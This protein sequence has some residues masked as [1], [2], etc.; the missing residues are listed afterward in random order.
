MKTKYS[1]EYKC[2]N[3]IHFF[4][5]LPQSTN[6]ENSKNKKRAKDVCSS[7]VEHFPSTHEAIVQPLVLKK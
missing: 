1:N 6:K 3:E 4:V 2:Y 7:V 5:C